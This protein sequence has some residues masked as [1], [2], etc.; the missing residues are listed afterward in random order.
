ME[1]LGTELQG[2]ETAKS[3]LLRQEQASHV[4]GKACKWAS[5]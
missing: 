1:I 4:K 5:G 2:E 3:K